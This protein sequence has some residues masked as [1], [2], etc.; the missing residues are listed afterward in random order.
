MYLI[1]LYCIQFFIRPSKV[2]H[3]DNDHRC[4]AHLFQ[5]KN[6]DDKGSIVTLF[7]LLRER[8]STYRSSYHDY[9]Q[10]LFRRKKLDNILVIIAAVR[11]CLAKTYGCNHFIFRKRA[12]DIRASIQSAIKRCF[13]EIDLYTVIFIVTSFTPCFARIT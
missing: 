4:T 7:A 1:D 11:S 10:M 8:T 12:W 13:G 5:Q 3:Q 9:T 2:L 6:Q